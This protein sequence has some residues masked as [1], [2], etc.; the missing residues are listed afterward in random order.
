[1]KTFKFFSAAA[2]LAGVIIACQSLFGSGFDGSLNAGEPGDVASATVATA[3]VSPEPAAVQPP[4]PAPHCEVP[5]G[6][7]AD[8]RRFEQMLED[9][10]TI[11]KA[12]TSVNE[13]HAAMG[14]GKADAT[15]IN[16]AMRWVTTKED[17]ATNTQHII[18]QY[19]MTQRI[20]AD[21]ENYAKQIAAAHK[22]MVTA[23]KC[24]QNVDPAIA[25]ALK[26]SILDLYRQYEG[27]EPQLGGHDHAHGDQQKVA[28]AGEA[29]DD[30]ADHDHADHD[31]HP[32]DTASGDGADPVDTASGDGG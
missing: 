16:Q 2:V 20:K 24:K 22:V 4:A 30:H 15:A 13:F 12:M 29:G 8:Q 21:H 26:E 19:F 10:H 23:M 31:G 28:T 9:T 3:T 11:E 25:G 17:H 27:K 14:E 5:C 7:Y 18:A 1:M 6:I 32:V